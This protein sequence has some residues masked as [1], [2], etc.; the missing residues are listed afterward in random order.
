MIAQGNEC[1]NFNHDRENAP[2]RYCPECG[3]VV[4][5]D[6]SIRRC[7]EKEHAR[8]R[9]ERDTYCVNCGEKLIQRM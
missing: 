3:E 1:P 4:N 9:R 7:N 2:V 5:K 6:I 8:S